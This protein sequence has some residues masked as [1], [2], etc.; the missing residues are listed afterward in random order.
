MLKAFRLLKKQF[1]PAPLLIHFRPGMPI[2]IEMDASRF[3]ILGILNQQ[4]LGPDG[5][6]Q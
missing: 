1:K 3:A 2:K 5:K 4:A 6:L